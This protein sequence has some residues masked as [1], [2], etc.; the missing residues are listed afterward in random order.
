[1]WGTLASLNILTILDISCSNGHALFQFDGQHR[2]CF[3]WTIRLM[4]VLEIPWVSF[5]SSSVVSPSWYTC[6]TWK[7]NKVLF[8]EFDSTSVQ[9]HTSNSLL[10]G[11]FG[12]LR[13]T[14][15]LWDENPRVGRTI[16][17]R[18]VDL[19]GADTAD[20]T[21]W[22]HSATWTA[23]C[24]AQQGLF[25]TNPCCHQINVSTKAGLFTVQNISA[26]VR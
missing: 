10:L 25:L 22:R 7:H 12:D 21:C 2:W 24:V 19:P 11:Y 15:C 6:S 17:L 3:P 5:I 4:Q 16:S 20:T 1:M 14:R 18:D 26:L 23:R 8:F 9:S 13:S